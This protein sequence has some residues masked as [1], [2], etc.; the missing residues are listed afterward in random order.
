MLTVPVLTFFIPIDAKIGEIIAFRIVAFIVALLAGVPV[1]SISV[2]LF[3]RLG[4]KF[5]IYSDEKGLYSFTDLFPI[6][7]L[8]W[9]CMESL[10]YLKKSKILEVE[11]QDSAQLKLNIYWRIKSCLSRKHSGKR[12]L[13]IEFSVCKGKSEEISQKII[14]LWNYYK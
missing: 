7:F 13:T 2:S 9:E 11:L 5:L 3:M 10:N 1:F 8:P 6:G 12:I 14:D 4:R